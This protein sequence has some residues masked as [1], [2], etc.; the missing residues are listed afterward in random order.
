MP[1]KT[2]AIE[3]R[4]AAGPER[5]AVIPRIERGTCRAIFAYDVGL[6]IDLDAARRR[7]TDI[8]PREAIQHKP[9]RLITSN[10]SR[11]R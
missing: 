3:R 9:V 8:R 11:H 10:I 6:S 7:I 2:T 4:P 5:A 1:Q